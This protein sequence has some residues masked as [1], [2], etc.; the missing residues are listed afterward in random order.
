MKFERKRKKHFMEKLP[1]RAKSCFLNTLALTLDNS[2]KGRFPHFQANQNSVRVQIL[3]RSQ[4]LVL[5]E[6]LESS[7]TE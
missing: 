7:V 6:L 4:R 2:A 3:V 5:P 1:K